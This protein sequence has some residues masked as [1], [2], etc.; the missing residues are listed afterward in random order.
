MHV[1][2]RERPRA[3]R[4]LVTLL[5]PGGLHILTLRHGPGESGRVMHPVSLGEIEALARDHGLAVMR[6]LDAADPMVRADVSWTTACLRLPDDGSLGLPLIRGVILNDDKSSTYKLGLLRAVAKIADAAPALAV[7]VADATDRVAVPLGLVALNWIRTYLPLVAAGLPQAPNNRGPDGLGF[8]KVG[9]RR[10]LALGVTAQDLRVGASF[11]GERA[12][13]LVAAIGEARRTIVAMPVRYTTLP[14][15]SAAVFEAVGKPMRVGGALTLTPEVLDA[16]GHLLVPG[17]LWR[18]M[19]RLGAWI[20]PVLVAEWA[21]LIRT[22]AMHMGLDLR[23]GT[24]EARLVWLE[25][26]RDTSLARAVASRL[27]AAGTPLVCVWS[28]A[29]LRLDGLDI[30]HTLP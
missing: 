15:A 30:D 29:R 18:T 3:F 4:K 17:P 5:K 1:P 13:A 8:A 24:V 6:A 25:P 14:N 27:A 11:V 2:P 19:L 28:G 22:Y 12:E 21:R 16:W 7:P 9:F 26:A 23:P 20:E 10:L